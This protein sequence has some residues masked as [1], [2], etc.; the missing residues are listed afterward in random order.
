MRDIEAD[1]GRFNVALRQ[2]RIITF[3]RYKDATFLVILHVGLFRPRGWMVT[4][5][6]TS[7]IRLFTSSP[8]CTPKLLR[9]FQKVP[10]TTATRAWLP[11]PEAGPAEAIALLSAFSQK[12][13]C[14][15]ETGF[16]EWKDLVEKTI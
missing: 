2:K 3:R 15:A 4:Y 9:H 12:W 8:C 1:G 6:N 11:D 7:K 16:G 10:G 13:Y 14:R 5:H